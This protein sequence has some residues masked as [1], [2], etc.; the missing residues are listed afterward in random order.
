MSE[1]NCSHYKSILTAQQEH[2]IK[3]RH[4]FDGGIELTTKCNMNCIH[5]YLQDTEQGKEMTTNQ[6][7]K[8]IDKLYDRGVLFLYFTGG[9]ILTRLDFIDI[10]IYAKQKGFIIDLLT[11]GTLLNE[12]I[13]RVFDKYPPSTVSISIY[14]KDEK[15]YYKVTRTHG[16]FERLINNL[17]LLKQYQI[18]TELKFIGMKQIF[19][20]FYEVEKISNEYCS[21]FTFSFEL[22]PT[23]KGNTITKDFMVNP[24]DIVSFEK[25]YE[26]TRRVWS[27][28]ITDFNPYANLNEDGPLYTCNI[29][30]SNFLIDHEGY[31]NA[32]NKYRLKKFNLLNCDFDEAWRYFKKIY[33]EQK[34]PKNYKCFHC[35]EFYM[36]SPCVATNE[37]ST[38]NPLKPMEERCKLNYLRKKEFSKSIYEAYRDEVRK[39]REKKEKIK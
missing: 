26:K 32:C 10:Y 23:L 15:S 35:K 31:I 33:I 1:N 24:E 38:G 19:N 28:N 17:K 4:P 30:T 22:F 39:Y 16:N 36:C 25:T 27:V 12:D 13:I 34:V 7:K 5:C 11:N 18:N 9:E 2:W 37:L 29:G 14:G 8:I 3:H 6:V 20:D 21:S